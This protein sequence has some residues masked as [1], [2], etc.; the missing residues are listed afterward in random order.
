MEHPAINVLVIDDNP[1]DARLVQELLS[2]SR[3][4]CYQVECVERLSEGLERKRTECGLHD[5]IQRVTM[6][7]DEGAAEG[8][9]A[10]LNPG[11]V[12]HAVE[13]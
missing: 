4:V 8:P 5:A 11:G 13:S 9:L 6:D 1:S 10:V 3:D 2:E 7:S 12:S